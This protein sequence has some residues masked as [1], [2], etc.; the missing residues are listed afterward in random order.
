LTTAIGL[1]LASMG[2]PEGFDLRQE[3]LT[4]SRGFDRLK[5]PLAI[6]CM[7]ALLTLFVYGNRRAM[8]LRNLELHLGMT[9]IDKEKPNAP[10]QF[11]GL[12]NAVFQTRWFESAQNFRLERTGGKDYTWKDLIAEIVEAPVHR[13]VQIVRDR[14]RAVAE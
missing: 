7:V 4:L 13:R 2:G 10:P 12:L 9:F 8:E 14:L 11:H 5:F 3:D 1:A 6:A